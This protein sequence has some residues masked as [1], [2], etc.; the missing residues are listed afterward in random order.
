MKATMRIVRV[1]GDTE[2]RIADV[3]ISVELLP[4]VVLSEVER[5]ELPEMI[6][7]M[8]SLGEERAYSDG[9]LLAFRRTCW[10]K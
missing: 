5:S 3:C 10:E 8:A 1:G 2:Q 9:A 7:L 4:G 6:D